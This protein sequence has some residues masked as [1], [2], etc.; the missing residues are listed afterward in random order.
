MSTTK[1]NLK[2]VLLSRSKFLSRFL[3]VFLFYVCMT[4]F[5]DGSN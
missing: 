3:N 2:F 5:V 4:I 1:R